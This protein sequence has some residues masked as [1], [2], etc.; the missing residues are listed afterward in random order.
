MY[1]D[2]KKVQLILA[3]DKTFSYVSY[4][5]IFVNSTVTVSLMAGLDRIGAA[6]PLCVCVCVYQ[7]RVSCYSVTV[8]PS[9]LSL[10]LWVS[11]LGRGKM[12]KCSQDPTAAP[13][14]GACG[15]PG[16][17]SRVIFIRHEMEANGPEQ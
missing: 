15:T 8:N 7:T 17:D 13:V 12:L 11:L 14:P 1:P 16:K 3:R 2:L 10:S 6:V 5:P 9:H 4:V